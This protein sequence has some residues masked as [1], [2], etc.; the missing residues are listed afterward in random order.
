[1]KLNLTVAATLRAATTA[2]TELPDA[3]PRLEA[4]LLLAQATG[5]SRSVFL[6]WPERAVEAASAAEFAALLHRRMNGEPIAYVRG[7]QA[8][9]T[10]DL[11]V[12]PATLIPRPATELLVETALAELA[13]DAAL[14]VADLGTGSGAIAAA[15]A[16]ERPHWWLLAVERSAAAVQLARANFQT[17]A[18]HNVAALHGDWLSAAASASFDA[19]LSNPPYIPAADP[20]LQRGDLRFEPLTALVAGDDGLSAIRALLPDATRCLRSGGLLALE[21]GFDQGA[22]VRQL[23]ATHGLQAIE[24]RRDLAGQERVTLGVGTERNFLDTS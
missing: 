15:L 16:S 24:T 21:H 9:W 5:W 3:S 18:L 14:R 19:I 13:A 10:L 22:A 7:R 4:E 12:A 8:F 6:A 17:Y 23:L 11:A 1:L 20:H 2:L